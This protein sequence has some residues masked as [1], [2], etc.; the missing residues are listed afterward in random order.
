MMN[1]SSKSCWFYRHRI[2]LHLTLHREKNSNH[3]RSGS[4]SPDNVTKIEITHRWLSMGAKYASL[5]T[6]IGAIIS[7][8]LKKSQTMRGYFIKNFQETIS[9]QAPGVSSWFSKHLASSWYECRISHIPCG[10][11][12][13]SH[14][15]RALLC[16]PV[17]VSLCQ[18]KSGELC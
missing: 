15:R 1:L 6:T 10:N 14:S 17:F 18:I 5:V 2:D 11:S 8:L 3:P 16:I 7:S 4:N 12:I 13:K 9:Y